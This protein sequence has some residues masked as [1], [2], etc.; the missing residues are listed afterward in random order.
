MVLFRG[1]AQR[2]QL[3]VLP[4]LPAGLPPQGA[5]RPCLLLEPFPT[6]RPRELPR[7]RRG[8]AENVR[9]PLPS[10]L[11]KEKWRKINSVEYFKKGIEPKWEDPRNAQGGRFVFP[12][13]KSQENKDELYQQLVFFLL[14]EDFPDSEHVCGFRFISP[15]N[16]QAH[17]RVE[18]WVDFNTDSLDLLK[19]YQELLTNLFK[20]LNFDSKSVKFLNNLTEPKEAKEPREG[21]GKDSTLGG[22]EGVNP[23]AAKKG[24]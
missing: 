10:Y 13:P 14:G 9:A 21:G 20:E 15:K 1:G 4:E 24:E 18:I 12:V 6:L 16:S 2:E 19:L 7:E 11:V 8:K 5:R 17:Y 23:E 3:E 22:K